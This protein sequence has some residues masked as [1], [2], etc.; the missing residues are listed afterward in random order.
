MTLSDFASMFSRQVT[1]GPGA[2]A[3]EHHKSVGNRYSIHCNIRPKFPGRAALTSEID[4]PPVSSSLSRIAYTVRPK[5]ELRGAEPFS[6]APDYHPDPNE[7]LHRR[8]AIKN[9][10]KDPDTSLTP[11]PA[12]YTPASPTTTHVPPQGGRPKIVL[13]DPPCSPGPKYDV[14]HEFGG[15]TP[16]FTIRPRTQDP[17]DRSQIPGIEHNNPRSP[18]DDSPLWTISPTRRSDMWSRPATPGPGAYEESRASETRIACKIRDR[19]K[20]PRSLTADVDY[21]ECRV[22]PESRQRTIGEKDR[23]E[24]WDFDRAIPGPDYMPETTLEHGAL[25]IGE[26]RPPKGVKES[27]G[28]GD[29]N[30]AN[31]AQFKQPVFTCKG[32]GPRD[33]WL[34]RKN[35]EPGPAHYDVRAGN[36]R[37]KWIIG[38][39]SISRTDRSTCSMREQLT[40]RRTGRSTSAVSTRQSK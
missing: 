4:F 40:S 37:P 34:P 25:T 38:D 39:R 1:P 12:D 14:L 35:E 6:P 22:F 9:K 24:F 13:S 23:H 10:Y 18:G 16:R 36:D 2:Y 21:G 8:V 29:Y 33:Q 3:I 19:L 30:P 28:P 11:G 15:A 5:T 26:K 32:F 31:P 7:F 17:S 20:E 27:P